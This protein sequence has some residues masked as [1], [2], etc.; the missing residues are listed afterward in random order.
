MTRTAINAFIKDQKTAYSCEDV[1]RC[2]LKLN[3]EQM[4]IYRHIAVNGPKRV[5]E[6]AQYIGKDRSTAYR[7]LQKLI[8][9]GLCYK[10]STP[11]KEGGYFFLYHS[12]SMDTI[13]HET[14]NC[15][16]NTYRK[17]MNA[18]RTGFPGDADPGEDLDI[19]EDDR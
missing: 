18:I 1:V 4:D 14:E 13:R 7:E 8:Q 3:S 19:Q 5:D 15:I 17:L 6:V 10:E 11:M 12:R 16:Q 2:V 9:C